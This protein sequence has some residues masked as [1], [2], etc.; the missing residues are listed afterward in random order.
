MIAVAHAILTRSL[1]TG[2]SG[3]SGGGE[4]AGIKVDGDYSHI[5]EVVSYDDGVL[6]YEVDG[7]R[8]AVNIP[9]KKLSNNGSGITDMTGYTMTTADVRWMIL[10][11]VAKFAATV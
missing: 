11:R 6:V 8:F 10:R 5:V 4:L 2:F 1:G 9:L 7:N 3:A